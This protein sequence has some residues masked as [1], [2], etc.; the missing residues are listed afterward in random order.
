[1]STSPDSGQTSV[2]LSSI[3]IPDAADGGS[4]TARAML[5][6]L[7]DRGMR[8]SL[9]TSDYGSGLRNSGD[10]DIHMFPQTLAKPMDL[11]LGVQ[12]FLWKEVRRASI[13]HFFAFY[14]TA[15]VWGA[16]M[17]RRNGVPYVVS[18][19]GNTIPAPG[20][21]IA[22]S[23]GTIKKR[24]YFELLAKPLLSRA[25]FIICASEMERDRIRGYV[26]GAKFV[27]LS[28][29]RELSAD[30][31]Q[32]EALNVPLHTR[33]AVFLGRLSPEKSLPFL[34]EVWTDVRKR[35]PGALLVI[36]GDDKL[37]PGYA[38]ALRALVAKLGIG[39]AVY[40]AGPVDKF[41]K[42]WL[43]EKCSCLVLPSVNENFGLV[44]VEAL[45]AGRPA[46][47]STGTPWRELPDAGVGR[48]LPLDRAVWTDCLC[49]YMSADSLATQTESALRCREWV[50]ENIPTWDHSAEEHIHLYQAAIQNRTTA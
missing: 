48:W 34:L 19:I 4:A 29:G 2:L 18:P 23:L 9:C 43:F 17:A 35:I 25:A 24:L 7:R 50:R 49:E 6:A 38:P 45:T 31:V 41:K 28:H 27:V 30:R 46:I 5:C 33:L 22:T 47:T 16:F 26:P 36:A 44:V 20:K 10:P 42:E 21:I 14:S 1:V 39:E 37:C 15:T 13:C 3:C 8:V 11:S 32:G 12:R 40:F